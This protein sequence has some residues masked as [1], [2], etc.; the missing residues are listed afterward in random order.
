MI[1]PFVEAD[2]REDA[3]VTT[4]WSYSDINRIY[5]NELG[6]LNGVRFVRSNLIP[7]WTGFAASAFTFTPGTQGS[8]ATNANYQLIVT[9]SDTQNQYESRI[10]QVSSAQSVTGP[11][12]S[13]SVVLPALPGFTFNIY[14]GTSA[15]PTTLGLS[16]QGPTTGSMVGQAVQLAPAQTVV[17]TGIG[18]AQVPPAAPATGVTVY[19]T[20]VFGKGAYAQVEL[21]HVTITGLFSADKSDPLNQ[22]RV[23]GWKVFYGTLIK[24]NQFFARIESSASNTGAFG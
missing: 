6:E 8:L 17:I 2:M 10:Y 7:S 24:N 15:S 9:A 19:P 14:I 1:Q 11:N 20:Y 23:I 13:V 16:P 18:Q 5:N 12:G 3:T 4:A 22:F 21:D